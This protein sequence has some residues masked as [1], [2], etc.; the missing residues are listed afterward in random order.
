MANEAARWTY[1]PAPVATP[2]QLADWLQARIDWIDANIH[3]SPT[4]P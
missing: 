2:E 3:S 1:R 4:S